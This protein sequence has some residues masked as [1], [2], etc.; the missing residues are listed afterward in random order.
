MTYRTQALPTTQTLPQNPIAASFGT[1]KLILMNTTSKS[2]PVPQNKGF[3]DLRTQ[4]NCIK[5]GETVA[6]KGFGKLKIRPIQL[7][8]EE[9]MIR[10]HQSISEE[11]IYMR[12]FEYL[13][14]DQRTSHDRLIRIC[15]NTGESYAIVMEASATPHRSE[16]ILAVGRITTTDKPYVA[17]FDTLITTEMKAP[18]LAKVLL[19]RLVILARAFGFQTLTGEL[20]V[21]DHDTLNLCRALGFSLQTVPEGAVWFAIGDI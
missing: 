2:L 4:P 10:F 11:S 16:S 15:N 14:L 20:L 1:K 12:Y 5:L 21:A 13:G 8:D 17:T 6:V 9:E 3:P 19:K 18:Q 7:D